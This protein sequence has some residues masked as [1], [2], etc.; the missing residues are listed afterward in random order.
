MK[1][2]G[3]LS[4]RITTTLGL[5]SSCVGTDSHTKSFAFV[6][7]EGNDQ[8]LT[9]ASLNANPLMLALRLRL[10][11]RSSLYSGWYLTVPL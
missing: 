5:A 9:R 8:L 10:R 4:L 7:F 6:G 11:G 1:H 2:R 3:T